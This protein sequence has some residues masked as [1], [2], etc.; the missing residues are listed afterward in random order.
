MPHADPPSSPL[1]LAARRHARDVVT[2]EVRAWEEAAVFPRAAAAAAAADGLLGLFAPATV[3]GKGASLAEAMDV[4]E[5]LGRGDAAYAFALS[6]HNAVTNAIARFGSAELRDRYAAR[7]VSGELLGGFSL[8]EPHAG[9]DAA[10]ITTRAVPVDGGWR[11]T[12]RKAWVSLAGEADVFVLVCRTG[13][14]RG[15]GDVL[16]LAVDA[17]AEGVRVERLYEKA[18]AAFLPIGEVSYDDVLVPS[19]A[20][21]APAGQG[22]RAALGAIDVAR[23]DIAAISVGL[24]AEALAIALDYARGR[25]AFGGTL[26]DLQSI[27]FALADVETD[28][29][30][31]RM[32]YRAA[33]A[34]LDEG[35]GTV[36]AAHAKRFCPDAALRAAITCSEVLGAYGLLHEYPLARFLAHAKMLQVVDGTT[37][38]QRIV[39]ARDLQRR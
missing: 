25:E 9:S 10:A 7:L 11:V 30:A 3:G 27:Q 36:L 22:M 33:A 14:E 20:L 2:P 34:A 35:R 16:M 31:G 26:L 4:F 39:I 6:M 28:V 12:G 19:D 32:L 23:V 29:V 24:A 17:R 21:I 1:A 5:E 37:E 38:V 15:T 18:A 13:S 8:T